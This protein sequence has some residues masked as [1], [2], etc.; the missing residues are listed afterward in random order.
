M[1]NGE[2]YKLIVQQINQR[3]DR[4]ED[5]IQNYFNKQADIW[6]GYDERIDNNTTKVAVI[7]DRMKQ[8]DER[9]K[10]RLTAIGIIVTIFNS[11]LAFILSKF[12]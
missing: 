6:R 3:I 9:E 2:M 5:T 8:S 12:R 7:Q 11:V 1:D 4:L 10:R